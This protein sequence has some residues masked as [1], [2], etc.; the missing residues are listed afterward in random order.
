MNTYMF[1]SDGSKTE[2][3]GS[4]WVPKYVDVTDWYT[5]K[6]LQNKVTS[7]CINGVRHDNV[8]VSDY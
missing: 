5:L 7:T 4:S 6:V 8:W 2:W 1:A 3:N